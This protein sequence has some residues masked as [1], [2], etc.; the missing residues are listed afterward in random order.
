MILCHWQHCLRQLNSGNTASYPHT[1]SNAQ[2]LTLVVATPMRLGALP[3]V[4]INSL[5]LKE[6]TSL[7]PSNYFPLLLTL[8]IIKPLP[9]V[10]ITQSTYLTLVTGVTFLTMTFNTKE[11]N[12][13]IHQSKTYERFSPY[14]TRMRTGSQITALHCPNTQTASNSPT[15]GSKL[16][17]YPQRDK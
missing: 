17:S 3:V 16:L 13:W 12:Q 8:L 14:T 1:H 2:N 7:I 6:L 9:E 11:E 5:A 4:I 10:L 15:C